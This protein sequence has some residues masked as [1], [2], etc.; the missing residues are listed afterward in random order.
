VGIVAVTAI[1]YPEHDGRFG[2]IV[3]LV[4]SAAC[5]G[6][7]L[8]RRLV[9]DAEN[10]ACEL[11]CVVME[12]TSARSRA[13]SH[14]IYL[15]LDYQ[16]WGIAVPAASKTSFPPPPMAS[17]GSPF[18]APRRPWAAKFMTA[19]RD[20]PAAAGTAIAVSAAQNRH[21]G[22]QASAPKGSLIRNYSAIWPR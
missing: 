10:A 15:N 3:A 4:V 18:P 12:V 2:P 5:R 1:P 20:D 7:E 6:Q 11:G 9:Q 22:M 16:G 14:P 17:Y 19:A 13:D 21:F 8:G